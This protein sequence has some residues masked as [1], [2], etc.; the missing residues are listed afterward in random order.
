MGLRFSAACNQCG[1]NFTVS[2]GGGFVFHELH[3]DKCG[4]VKGVGFGVCSFNCVNGHND[5]WQFTLLP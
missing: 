1:F 4:K 3:C 2:E 5:S